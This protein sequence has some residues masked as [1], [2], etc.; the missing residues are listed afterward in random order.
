MMDPFSSLLYSVLSRV[1]GTF[2][3]GFGSVE[4]TLIP[5][6]TWYNLLSIIDVSTEVSIQLGTPYVGKEQKAQNS[7]SW[8]RLDHPSTWESRIITTYSVGVV[9]AWL[10]VSC[11][12]FSSSVSVVPSERTQAQTG[13]LT[14]IYENLWRRHNDHNNND[15]GSDNCQTHGSIPWVENKHNWVVWDKRL[16]QTVVHDGERTAVSFSFIYSFLF[17]LK[18]QGWRHRGRDTEGRTADNSDEHFTAH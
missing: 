3:R 7:K 17:I 10:I 8:R 5:W 2:C 12:I 6:S 16:C 14:M 11:W 1:H 18:T 13:C 9:E 15:H 4:N